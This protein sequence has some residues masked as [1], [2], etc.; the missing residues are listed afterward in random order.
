M[1]DIVVVGSIN[2]DMVVTVPQMPR[3][4]ETV[5]GGE[6]QQIAGGK[7]AN[8]AVA[9]ARAGG[10]VAMIGCTGDDAM[11]AHALDGLAQAGVEVSQVQ[12]RQ[13]CPS[14][15]ALILVDEAGEN[16]IAVAPGANARLLPSDIRAAEPLLGTAKVLLVQLEISLETVHESCAIAHRHGVPVILDPAPVP[17][18]GIDKTLWSHIAAITPNVTEIEALTGI[19]VHNHDDARDA[20]HVLVEWGVDAA[21]MT[22]GRQG[23]YLHSR[24]T[25][26]PVGGLAVTVRDT[27]AAGDVFAGAMAARLSEGAPLIDAARF[28]NAAAA[29]A[30]TRPGAQPSAPYRHEINA[31]L[32][33]R[34]VADPGT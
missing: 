20:G 8:Q 25:S 5:L 34:H 28:A 2:T 22:L 15:V 13:E 33:S 18:S 17:P 7:G 24:E 30:V 6:F 19:A 3:A 32:E 31:M 10:R 12:R 16:C 23:L 21:V 1:A 26:L 11:G 4:G 9:A 29:I 27:T 14:G